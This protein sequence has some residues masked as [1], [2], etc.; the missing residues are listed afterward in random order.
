MESIDYDTL[1]LSGGSSKGIVTLG[2]IQY[3]YDTFILN[4]IKTYIGTSS[5]A[6]ICY[7]LLIGYTPI[8]IMV[9]ICTH[10]LLEK[11][12]HFNVVAMIQGGGASSFNSIQE[13]LEKMTIEKL[14]YLPTLQDLKQ[15]YGKTLICV[16]YNLTEEKAEYLSPETTGELPCITALRMS[17]NLPFVFDQFKYGNSFYLDGGISD[18]FAIDIGD[19]LGKKIIGILIVPESENF[20]NEPDANI[21]EFI[22]KLMFIP[23]CQAIDYK[24]ENVSEKCK[25][26][27]LKYSKIKF[28]NFALSSRTKFEM[29]SSGYQQMKEFNL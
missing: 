12:Q 16:T 20:N 1:V 3:C 23:I 21:L 8:E 24:I 28:F 11:L 5:G 19:K 10:Q 6:I 13:Q 25:I 15:K 29:F 26:I 18:N 22:Y 27:K 4:K 9:Y 14:G 2:A 17:S 7:L